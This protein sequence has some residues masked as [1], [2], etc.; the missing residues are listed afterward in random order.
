MRLAHIVTHPIQYY[1]PL[2]RELS[3]RPEIDLTVFF[4]SDFSV[5]EYEDPGFGRSVGWDTPLLDGYRYRFLPSAQ[6]LSL[7][8]I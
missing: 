6:G 4:A 5:R 8:H 2:Y 7:I 1:A 3:S